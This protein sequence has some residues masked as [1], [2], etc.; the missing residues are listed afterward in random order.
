[1]VIHSPSISPRRTSYAA[2][3]GHF[4]RHLIEMTI[5]MMVGMAAT[6]PVLIAIFTVMNVTQDEALRRYPELICLVVAAGMIAAMVAWMRYRG[7]DLRLCG[8]M[9]TAMVIPLVPIF[10]LLWSGVIA[11]ENA[12]GIYCIAMIPAMLSAMLIRRDEYSEV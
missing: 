6:V 8:E 7:H 3:Y 10:A 11:G 9:A 12:C 4:L 1:M 2:H 5:A